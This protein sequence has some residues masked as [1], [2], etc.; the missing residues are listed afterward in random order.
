MQAKKIFYAIMAATL[1]LGGCAQEEIIQGNN[2]QDAPGVHVRLAGAAGSITRATTVAADDD[3]KS[4]R[5]VLAVLYDTHD[6]FYKTVE[7][8]QVGTTNEYTFIVEKDA[9]Y[10]IY[11]VANAD[12]YLQKSLEEIPLGSKAD[13]ETYGLAKIVATQ[14]PDVPNTFLMVSKY[15]EKVT[16]RITEKQS[17]GEVHMERLAARF[18][19]VNK[20]EGITVNKLTFTNRTLRS[21]VL[22]D[23]VMSAQSEWFEN[24]EYDDLNL[25]GEK[26]T[27]N[28]Y[29]KKIYTYENYSVK[30]DMTLP[31]LTIEYTEGDQTKTH[32]ISLIDPSATAGTTLAIKRNHLYRIVLTKAGKLDFDIQ[33]LDWDTD[34]DLA[35]EDIPL[36]LPDDEQEELN[37]N[38]MVYDLFTEYNV[39]SLDTGNKVVTFYDKLTNDTDLSSHFNFNTFKNSGIFADDVVFTDVENNT[40]RIPT[41]GEAQLLVPLFDEEYTPEMVEYNADNKRI[42]HSPRGRLNVSSVYSDW[43]DEKVYLKNNA[44]LSQN[45]ANIETENQNGFTGASIFA[46][47]RQ[48]LEFRVN[49]TTFEFDNNGT[50]ISEGPAYGIRF[51]GTD[52]Y[53]AYKWEMQLIPGS[54]TEYYVSIKIKAL[55]QDSNVTLEDIVDN[56]SYWSKNYIEY[57]FP[58]SGAIKVENNKPTNNIWKKN[59]FAYIMCSTVTNHDG[60]RATGLGLTYNHFYGMRFSLTS[61]IPLRLIKCK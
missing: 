36:I 10:N 4:V 18:D 11:L 31:K 6:G 9:T 34:E 14:A 3:E 30:G 49:T 12:A 58:M 22:T 24:R 2:G 15:P 42:I 17:I 5:N 55:K 27:G 50:Y 46:N 47:G 21:T 40:Y 39:K 54:M 1:M 20:A 35:Y 8:S 51:K 29:S 45:K 25:E 13:D 26:E 60:T 37:K 43:F 56:R 41:I 38:L 48:T 19:L 44:D 16:T 33:V 61:Y 7:A 53:A 52:Q 59:T 28:T 32:E 23:N 57:K